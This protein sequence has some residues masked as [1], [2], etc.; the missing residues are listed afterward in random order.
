[1]QTRRLTLLAATLVAL[2]GAAA[3]RD[4]GTPPVPMVGTYQLQTVNGAPLPI[5]TFSGNTKDELI[6]E[7]LVLNGDAERTFTLSY[8]DRLT[9]GSQSP[10]TVPG[11]LHGTF[12]QAGNSLTFRFSGTNIDIP[13]AYS[14]GIINQVHPTRGVLIYSNQ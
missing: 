10:T 13:A 3:C 11:S 1:M 7:T 4:E 9:V 5:T 12:T 8:T 2:L 6:Q 14:N